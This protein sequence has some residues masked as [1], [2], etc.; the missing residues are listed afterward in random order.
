MPWE[1]LVWCS[2]PSSAVGGH[3][4]AREGLSRSWPRSGGGARTKGSLLEV[5]FRGDIGMGEAE[6]M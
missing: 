1:A 6:L 4:S 2:Q 3:P 5:C